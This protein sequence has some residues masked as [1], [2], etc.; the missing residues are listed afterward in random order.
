MHLPSENINIM[1]SVQ[2]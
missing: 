2:I 1:D